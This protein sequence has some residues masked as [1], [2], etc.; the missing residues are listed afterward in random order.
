MKLWQKKKK[1]EIDI[2]N[3]YY[4]GFVIGIIDDLEIQNIV[5]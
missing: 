2:K 4:L 3:L 1:E 5:Y